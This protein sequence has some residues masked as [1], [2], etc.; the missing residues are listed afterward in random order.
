MKMGDYKREFSGQTQ[1]L[2]K[3]MFVAEIDI[4]NKQ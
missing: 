2:G 4:R 3:R 1:K